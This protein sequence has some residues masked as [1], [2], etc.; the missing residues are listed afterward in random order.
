MYWKSILN[1]LILVNSLLPLVAFPQT[2]KTKEEDL[3]EQFRELKK[4]LMDD[5]FSDSDGFMNDI[6][7]NLFKSF[8]LGADLSGNLFKSRWHEEKDGQS[9]NITPKKNAELK[10]VVNDGFISIEASEKSSHGMSNSTVSLNVPPDLDWKKH[11]IS[12]KGEDIV[13]YFPYYPGFDSQKRKEKTKSFSP[14]IEPE[15]DKKPN[16]KNKEDGMIPIVP[17]N[18]YDV[19]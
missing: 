2:S 9:F 11:S 3:Y 10:I 4:K 6:D 1:L 16:S 5:F 8:G 7:Q 19:I 15:N 13:V 12:K 17:S 18:S 14:H